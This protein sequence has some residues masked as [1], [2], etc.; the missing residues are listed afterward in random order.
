VLHR[1]YYGHDCVVLVGTGQ[2]GHPLRVR[3]PG[4]SPV[5]AG[6]KVLVSAQGEVIAWPAGADN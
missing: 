6:D 5:Q 3:C 4:G 1:E 2:D